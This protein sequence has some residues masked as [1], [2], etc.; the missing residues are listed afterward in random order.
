MV[1]NLSISSNNIN[2]NSLNMF[3]K[4]HSNQIISYRIITILMIY[5]DF[6]LYI[7]QNLKFIFLYKF[8]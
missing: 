2:N 3:H 7:N 4:V 1:N 5:F 6:L 8:Q